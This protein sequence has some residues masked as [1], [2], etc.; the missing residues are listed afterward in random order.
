MECWSNVGSVWHRAGVI[1]NRNRAKLE[2]LENRIRKKVLSNS[3][4]PIFEILM[5]NIAS[6][7]LLCTYIARSAVHKAYLF[8]PVYASF[9][10]RAIDHSNTQ[11]WQR[12][13]RGPVT[14][15]E[16]N[17][18]R[19]SILVCCNRQDLH[20]L[21]T[22]FLFTYQFISYFCCNALRKRHIHR[23]SVKMN[24]MSVIFCCWHL[25]R[26]L[27]VVYLEASSCEN[28]ASFRPLS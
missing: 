4:R 7:A 25:P 5:S 12:V 10:N 6:S 23:Q 17:F 15:W 19:P 9:E 18:L 20:V 14:R 28:L 26:V 16:R 24:I 1:F 11:L 3:G 2:S 13:K 21:L 27:V 8:L 22:T